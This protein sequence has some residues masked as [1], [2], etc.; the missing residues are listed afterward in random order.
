MSNSEMLSDRF[1]QFKKAINLPIEQRIVDHER[2]CDEI[3]LVGH[4]KM[5]SPS[6]IIQ[7]E[8][9][10]SSSISNPEN[11]LFQRFVM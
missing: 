5:V 8:T 9:H 4:E 11:L 3:D 6:I 10:C 2:A 7:G 1:R